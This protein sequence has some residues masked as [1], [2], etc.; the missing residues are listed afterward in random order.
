MSTTNERVAY[1]IAEWAKRYGIGRSKAY[2]IIS[3][4][5]GPVT[6]DING[7]TRITQEADDEWRRQL[8]AQAARRAEC[9]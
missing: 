3:S 7:V 5:G 1:S 4:G 6:V 9:A 8:V 2:T